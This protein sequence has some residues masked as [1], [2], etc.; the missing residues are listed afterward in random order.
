MS[1]KNATIRKTPA[2]KELTLIKQV[3][4]KSGYFVIIGTLKMLV[5]NLNCMFVI[6]VTMYWWLLMNYAVILT[7][8]GADY[9]FILWSISKN[10]AVNVSDNSVLEGK[11]VL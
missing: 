1:Y 7:I 5:L 4:Q 2:L 3:H 8:K 11:G 9:R 6:N 10:E